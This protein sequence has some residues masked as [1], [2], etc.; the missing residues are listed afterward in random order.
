MLVASPLI[1]M[2]MGLV[3]I[4]VLTACDPQ[5]AP[6]TKDGDSTET[7]STATTTESRSRQ[8]SGNGDVSCYAP[9]N[10]ICY[11]IQ[12]GD[13]E[14]VRNLLD[15]GADVNTA[16]E[17]GSTLLANAITRSINPK[18]EMVQILVDAGADVNVETDFHGNLVY[19][20]I[21]YLSEIELA[22]RIRIVEILV[23]AGADVNGTEGK[24]PLQVASRK[25][26]EDI[27]RI[28]VH[29]GAAPPI[30]IG[31]AL[32]NELEDGIELTLED[33]NWELVEFLIAAGADP[34]VQV[35]DF[36]TVLS[37]AA[38]TGRTEMV[39]I[40]VDAGADPDDGLAPILPVGPRNHDV[41]WPNNTSEI[42]QI[43]LDAGANPNFKVPFL[44]ETLLSLAI[45]N[46]DVK[47]VRV[48]VDA[49]ADVKKGGRPSQPTHL[50]EAISAG[51]QAI[52][53]VLRSASEPRVLPTPHPAASAP[54]AFMSD[55]DGN[56][57]IYVMNADGSGVTNL[58]NNS[59]GDGFPSWSPDGA[60]IAFVSD[61]DGNLEIYVMNADGSG[62]TN[63]TNNS[64]GDGSPSWSPD[65]ARIAFD[66]DRDG[67]RD[68]H[69]YVMNG[70]GSDVTNLT[71][72]S[73]LDTHTS[74]SWSPD[75]QRIAFE[76]DGDIYVMNADGSDLT[77]LTRLI[78]F[79]KANM[80]PSWSPDGQRIAFESNRHGNWDIY[81]MNPDG[82]GETKLT[83]SPANDGS[84]SWSPDGQHIA[85][86]SD[87]DGN[88][89]IY[90][91][92]TDGPGVARLTKDPAGDRGPNWSP[93]GR[94]R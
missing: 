72:N 75:G 17:H 89:D 28:L 20:A 11:A 32:T 46:D 21:A 23:N 59:A 31:A 69:I 6:E 42:L 30:G 84:P 47:A 79:S 64:A 70:D 57:E 63:L 71:K 25:D 81:V 86:V 58:T 50:D 40:L 39:R 7:T 62:V 65:G 49:G 53:E 48:L 54:I 61:R 92:D 9:G 78:G 1:R 41:A 16:D 14:T 83:K 15:R 8:A 94:L 29:A 73:S 76:S 85:F 66:S 44:D 10:D 67:N 33:D 27:I 35:H 3:L 87:R 90:I 52:V 34:N 5:A 26:Y 4:T 80:S 45:A 36:L 55:R 74:P 68:M 43:L 93:D 88:W 60:R 12:E 38:G 18:A 37:L 77:R 13:V 56:L 19:A 51:N 82:S 24:V 22:E 91:M 2:T